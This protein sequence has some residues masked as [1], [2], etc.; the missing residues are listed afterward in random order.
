MAT[1][2]SILAYLA[3]FLLEAFK[4]WQDGKPAR[5]VEDRNEEIQKGRADIASGNAAAVSVRIDRVP[6]IQ[7][8]A[9]GNT[10]GV[11]DGPD[12]EGDSRTLARMAALGCSSIETAGES[13]K[14]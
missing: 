1:A 2:L 4:A 6:T 13:G 11:G 7:T 12:R 5:T 8:G 10:P 9:P 14:L 3:P